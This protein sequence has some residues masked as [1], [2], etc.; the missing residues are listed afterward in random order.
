MAT[1]AVISTPAFTSP[2]S[3]LSDDYKSSLDNYLQYQKGLALLNNRYSFISNLQTGSFGKVTCA[4]DIQT[5][6]KVAIKA[7]KQSINGVTVMANHEVSIMKSLGYHKN[8]IQLLDFFHTKKYHIMVLE[9]AESGDLYDAIHN[10]TSLGLNL[11]NN[12]LSFIDFINQLLDVMT[13]IHQKG[14]YHR[15][16]KPENILLM[17]DGTIKLCDWGLS[18]NLIRSS[19]FNVGTEKY[20]APEAL[21]KNDVDYYDSNKVD[22]YSVAITLLFTLFNKC[23]FRKALK[24]DPNYSNFLKS[25]F[26]IYDFFPNINSTSFTSIVDMLMI[27]RDLVGGL[28]YLIDIG[29][30]NGFTLDQEHS[31]NSVN[32]GNDYFN[33]IVNQFNNTTNQNV[34]KNNNNNNNNTIENDVF[35]FEDCDLLDDDVFIAATTNQN[36]VENNDSVAQIPIS[37][38]PY[39][40]NMNPISIPSFSSSSVSLSSKVKSSSHNFAGSIINS[41]ST[42]DKSY[43]PSSLFDSNFNQNQNTNSFVNSFEISNDIWA[44]QFNDF[45][46]KFQ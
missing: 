6:T 23:P 29:Y 41:N 43:Q 8:I 17:N 11:Q 20:M 14:I 27:K 45:R 7:M 25:K 34:E 4:L 32:Q 42:Y 36:S 44:D 5:N 3:H 30:K 31:I 37:T 26:F 33:S 12:Y 40:T 46:F 13:F 35:L 19:D 39:S 1:P 15:D 21:I 2:I 16:I 9:Y 18:T 22:A 10:K 28:K 38:T 24:S